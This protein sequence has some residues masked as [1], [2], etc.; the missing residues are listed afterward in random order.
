MLENGRLPGGIY[1]YLVSPVRSDGAVDAAVLTALVDDLI[2]AGVNGVSPLGS[3][4]E[5]MYLTQAQ[6]LAVVEIT[7][8]AVQRRVPVV[9]GVCAFSTHDAIEQGTAYARLGVDGLVV[10][11]QHAFPVDD[12]GVVEFFGTVA[13]AVECP[14]L[15][16]TNPSV[17]GSDL[18]L[19]ALERLLEIPNV[20]YLKDASGNTGRILSVLSHFGDRLGVFSAS[21]HIPL[22]VF[23]LGGIGWMAGPACVVPEAAVE[24]LRLTQAGEHAAALRLQRELWPL[25]EAFTSY[26]LGACIKAALEVRGYAV[27]QPISPQRPLAPSARAAVAAAISRA[28]AAVPP[29]RARPA[30]VA[31]HAVGTGRR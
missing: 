26:G 25:N 2:A 10:M 24:L 29:R 7:L 3:T 17:L 9:P 22:L 15:L 19:A 11:R 30:T 12:D 16:Y 20:R 23:E 1:P 14:V 28:D 21:A 27:G 5:V 4:G 13:K 8:G 6:R 18:S 31:G